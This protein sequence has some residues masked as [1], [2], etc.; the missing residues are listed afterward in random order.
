MRQEQPSYRPLASLVHLE[1]LKFAVKCKIFQVNPSKKGC[2]CLPKDD[3]SIHFLKEFRLNGEVHRNILRCILQAFNRN[4][5]VI[6]IT[7]NTSSHSVKHIKNFHTL[8]GAK[9][10]RE[11]LTIAGGAD[12]RENLKN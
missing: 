6:K 5:N 12:G 8:S 4:K 9:L 2:W 1:C 11:V 10:K 7:S 3:S